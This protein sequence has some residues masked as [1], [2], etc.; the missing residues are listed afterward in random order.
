MVI[1]D[2]SSFFY[3][4]GLRL[5]ADIRYNEIRRASARKMQQFAEETGRVYIPEGVYGELDPA[6]GRPLLSPTLAVG[7][8]RKPNRK[9]FRD[10]LR[11][12]GKIITKE[13]E[14]KKRL[15]EYLRSTNRVL[16]FSTLEHYKTLSGV[17]K[18]IK[19]LCKLNDVDWDFLVTGIVAL[20]EQ[21]P[22]CLVSNDFDIG[23][24]WSLC[25]ECRLF[26]GNNLPFYLRKK[27]DAYRNFDP[28]K[29]NPH[30]K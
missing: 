18:G 24:A 6:G 29:V 10:T 5:P 21:S 26:E 22:V 30:P 23:K 17:C 4:D 15:I 16:D 2:T 8:I 14:A 13:R 11:R 28:S 25:L 3:L 12:G 20:G 1:L 9:H 27:F 19:D 7:D